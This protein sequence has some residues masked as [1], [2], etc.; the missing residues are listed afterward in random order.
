MALYRRH[1]CL[2]AAS[3]L[4]L[5]SPAY[6]ATLAAPNVVPINAL[7]VTSGQ[8]TVPALRNLAQLNFGAVL[9]LAPFTVNDA[10]RE[11]PALL[12]AQGIDFS[13][14]PIPFGEPT[15]DLF[16]KASEQILRFKGK[17]TLVHCQ[18]N[19][20]ASCMVFLHRVIV[21]KELPAPAYEAVSKVWSPHGPWMSLLK[22]QLRKHRVDFEPI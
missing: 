4:A 16:L 22:Q 7:L 3:P 20:R 21:E 17:R 2:L 5:S 11:E 8:P 14:V 1:F 6:A 13:H 12:Q 19:M 15:E 18:V 9:Y 10:V